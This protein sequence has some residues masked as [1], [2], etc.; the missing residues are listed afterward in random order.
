MNKEEELKDKLEVC[1]S[2][3]KLGFKEGQLAEQERIIELIKEIEKKALSNYK[4]KQK[5]KDD[6]ISFE[7][8][9][10]EELLSKIQEKKE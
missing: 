3:Y 7:P 2:W 8:E 1:E 9:D 10:W 6:H 5:I 4:W